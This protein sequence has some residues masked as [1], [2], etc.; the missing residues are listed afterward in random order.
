LIF[1]FDVI[2]EPG[3]S[4]Q[5]TQYEHHQLFGCSLSGGKHGDLT[6][7]NG[8]HVRRT[9]K[10]D[11]KRLSKP[12]GTRKQQFSFHFFYIERLHDGFVLRLPFRFVNLG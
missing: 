8:Q 9:V 1:D 6:V 4:R 5:E 7:R 3:E 11:R 10:S 12:S 2:F